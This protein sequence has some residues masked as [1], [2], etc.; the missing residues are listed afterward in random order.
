MPFI[1]GT[2]EATLS[3]RSIVSEVIGAE[4]LEYVCPLGQGGFGTVFKCRYTPAQA[5]ESLEN[6][7]GPP[8]QDGSYFV[9]VKKL[10]SREEMLLGMERDARDTSVAISE[11]AEKERKDAVDE[12]AR[13]VL[14][15][16][17]LRHPNV[18]GYIGCSVF[19]S[20]GGDGG[21]DELALVLEYSA[22][23]SLKDL[24]FAPAR[25]AARSYT[26]VEGLGWAI[27]IARGMDFLHHCKP[28]IMHR[29]LKP[30]NIMIC[31]AKDGSRVAKVADFGLATLFISQKKGL[32][33][34]ATIA[35][36]LAGDNER[37]RVLKQFKT[38]GGV[39]SLHYMAR[40]CTPRKPFFLRR[41]THNRHAPSA[42]S[43]GALM[44]FILP[45]RAGVPAPRAVALHLWP[46]YNAQAPENFRG[47]Q[48]TDHVDQYS[49]G[50]PQLQTDAERSDRFGLAS[51]QMQCSQVQQHVIITESTSPLCS[52][53]PSPL[54]IHRVRR[55]NRVRDPTAP[56]GLGK[57]VP[58][59]SAAR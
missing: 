37:S 8:A 39:G 16:K 21:G 33:R 29:D 12:F 50:A 48:Y 6:M 47:E 41:P 22:H 2:Q 9:A 10:K 30:G 46:P 4:E 25:D 11:K 34:Q 55:H 20:E 32:A 56:E 27:D 13:E 7:I 1:Q 17:T 5:H 35:L 44:Q 23:G 24:I 31:S 53:P 28:P 52:S 38:T 26:V 57:R 14:M 59:G 45:P 49:Y 40:L 54:P 3:I 58:H 15:L 19:G 43:A 42:L 51:M 18:I 36:A